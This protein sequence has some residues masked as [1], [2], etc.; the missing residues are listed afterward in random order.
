MH[1]LSPWLQVLLIILKYS[2]VADFHT[3]HFTVANA[4]GLSVFTRR[5]RATDLD[6]DTD[7]SNHYEVALDGLVTAQNKLLLP[8]L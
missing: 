2:A 8:S 5:L 1:I 4:L 3:L 7:T 6:T